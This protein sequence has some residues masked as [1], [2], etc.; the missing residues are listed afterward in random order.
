MLLQIMQNEILPLGYN[1]N[2]VHELTCYLM[3]SGEHK[4]FLFLSRQLSQ[5]SSDK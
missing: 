2:R 5:P 1:V 3:I 4:A